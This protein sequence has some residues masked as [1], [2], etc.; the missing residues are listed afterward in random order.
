MVEQRR[1]EISIRKVLGA[2]M[3]TLFNLLTLDFLK[4]IVISLVIAIPIGYYAMREWLSDY[5]YGIDLTWDIFVIAG[6]LTVSIALFTISFESF[7]LIRLNPIGNLR[8][9]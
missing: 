3:S 4:L 5:A 1:K 9:E 7:K 8:S 6:I 2:S